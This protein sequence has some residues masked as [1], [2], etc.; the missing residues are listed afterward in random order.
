MIGQRVQACGWLV[1]AA[2]QWAL[3]ASV[4]VA[5]V[6]ADEEQQ[7]YA[8]EAVDRVVDSHDHTLLI[9]GA[10]LMIKQAA[11]R[12]SRKL[13][14][15]WGREAGLDGR[16][17]DSAP[18]Y[19]AAKADLLSVADAAIAQ[20]VAAGLW[21]KE[22][23]SE[24]TTREFN[25]EEA[26]VIATHFQSEGGRKQRMLMD[27]YLGEMVLFNYTFTDSFEYELQESERELLAL[28]REAQRRIPREDVEFSSRYPDSFRFIAC[29][30]QG[31][32]CP[33]VK[34]WKMLAIPLM[35]EIFRYMDR[36]S[37]DIDA[38]MRSRR[39]QVQEHI[40]AFKARAP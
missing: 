25:G 34:Y 20:R 22:A 12:S 38:Q 33:G 23:W 29:S 4:A 3:A 16:W 36:V 15:E 35:G 19:R 39:P 27:W 5:A 6:D 11:I 28:Q 1:C 2:A 40:Q 17:W 8:R 32:Y 21:V 18:E 10:K 7:R 31:R 9:G 26:D 30:P 13:L 37:A 24:Y 14:A